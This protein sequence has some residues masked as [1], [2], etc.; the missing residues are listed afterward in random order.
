MGKDQ[1]SS[2]L[3]RT[4]NQ[5]PKLAGKT[6]SASAVPT[7]LSSV[8]TSSPE[9]KHNVTVAPASGGGD[10]SFMSPPPKKTSRGSGTSVPKKLKIHVE[11][12]SSQSPENFADENSQSERKMTPLPSLEKKQ[13]RRWSPPP[14]RRMFGDEAIKT[15]PYE[16]E[17]GRKALSRLNHKIKKKHRG[18]GPV[19]NYSKFFQKRASSKK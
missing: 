1:K 15:K 12:D 5:P 6:R 11:I 4:P 17:E 16:V 8:M 18:K 2:S 19:V 10:Q 14:S 7:D 13:A 9:S 3:T